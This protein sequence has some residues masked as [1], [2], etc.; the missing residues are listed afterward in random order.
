MYC[1]QKNNKSLSR[2]GSGA[3]SLTWRVATQPLSLHRISVVSV[4]VYLNIATT[5]DPAGQNPRHD[6]ILV[7]GTR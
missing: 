5:T 6:A 3:L 1:A 7:S 4:Y 2:R